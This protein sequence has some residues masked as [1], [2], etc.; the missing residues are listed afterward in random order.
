MIIDIHCHILP[1]VDDGARDERSTKKMLKIAAEEGIDAIVATPH[2]F[3]GA[4]NEKAREIQARYRK[5]EKWW[6][7]QGSGKKLYL[8]NELYYG[9]GIVD[10]LNQG[11]AL[12]M[13]GTRYVLVEFPEYAEFHNIRT[14]VQKLLYAG[15]IPILAHIERY[16]HMQKRANIR[17]LA[18]MGACMQSNVSAVL[19]ERG[20]RT[21]RFLLR[22]MKDNLLHFVGT[23]AHGTWQRKPQMQRCIQYLEKKLGITTAHRILEENPEKMLKGEI[24]NG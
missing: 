5:V 10:A 3:Y 4:D 20:F 19:G 23:D 17:E 22:L 7:A 16:E 13:N 1:G 11:L 24:I 18:E 9:E 14:A 6:K 15:Y 2:F 21:K 8:G 12:T